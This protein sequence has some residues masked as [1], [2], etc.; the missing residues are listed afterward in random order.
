MRRRFS[1]AA[2][3]G[4]RPGRSGGNKY[5]LIVRFS[6][7]FKSA[8]IKFVGTHSEYN[9]IDPLTVGI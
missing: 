9:K 8:Q 6:Y 3:I 5:R 7:R 4:G 1:A 2:T